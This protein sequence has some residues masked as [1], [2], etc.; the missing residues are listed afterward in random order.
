M[1]VRKNMHSKRH[2]CSKLK[3]NLLSL[4]LL[5]TETEAKIESIPAEVI[6]IVKI[7]KNIRTKKNQVTSLN[8]KISE[9]ESAL[10]TKQGVYEKVIAF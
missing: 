7:N 1:S 4:E 3:D 6:D 2:T 5:C 9:D 10:K 8:L